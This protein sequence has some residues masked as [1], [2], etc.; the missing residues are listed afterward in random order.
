[1]QR[2]HEEIFMIGLHGTLS[3][4]L[5][6]AAATFAASA[7]V[8]AQQYPAKP[9]KLIVP[10]AP[11]GG[12][13]VIGRFMAQRL[14]AALGQ[15][16]F[17]ENRA[18]AGGVIGVEA[19]LKSPPDGYTLMLI[20]SS[21]TAYPSIYKLKFD[22]IGDLAPIIQIS[23]G[24]LL[25]VVH[26]SLP[27]RTTQDLIALA[28]SRPGTLNF[29]S[30]GLGTTLQLATELFANMAGIKLNHVPYK[31]TGPALADA[32]AGHTDLYFSGIAAA[33]P[34]VRSGRLRAIAVTTTQRVAAA[35]DVP[36]VAESGVPDYEVVVWY[37]LGGPKGLPRA[38]VERINSEVTTALTSR[39]VEEQLQNDGLS[40]AGGTP[41]QFLARIKREIE[42]WRKVVKDAGV[43]AE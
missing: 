20:P 25:V 29:A 2:P 37:G 18:G 4:V 35:P 30:P 40:P 12:S 36:T 39:E 14:T 28:R 24:P 5:L 43:K 26:P 23:Q 13:D 11:G 3:R 16:V 6:A 19:G 17:V 41:E 1:V 7:Q 21:Y 42:V 8:L 31:G 32:I 22:P 15:Q 34:H 9:V 33:L 38:I 27:V 10:F